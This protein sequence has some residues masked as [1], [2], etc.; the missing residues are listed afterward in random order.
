MKIVV[1]LDHLF[2]FRGGERMSTCS[3][4]LMRGDDDGDDDCSYADMTPK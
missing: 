4:A 3:G 1:I 2:K